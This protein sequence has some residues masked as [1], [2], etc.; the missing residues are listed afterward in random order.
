MDILFMIWGML[1]ITIFIGAGLIDDYADAI[2]KIKK[3]RKA[4][5]EDRDA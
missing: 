4:K 3:H 1:L 5:K 2:E